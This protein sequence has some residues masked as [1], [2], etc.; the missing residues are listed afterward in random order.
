MTMLTRTRLIL[1]AFLAAIVAGLAFY[2]RLESATQ[3]TAPAGAHNG[4]QA[5]YGQSDS[6]ATGRGQGSGGSSAP[7]AVVTAIAAKEDVSVTADAVGFV[8]PIATVALRA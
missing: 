1:L 6:G 8:E 7:V 3:S 4:G 2:P 5:A